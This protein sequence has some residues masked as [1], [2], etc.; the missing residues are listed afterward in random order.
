M[1]YLH[2][3]FTDKIIRAFYNVYNSLGFGFL[4][5]V[6]ENAMMIELKSFGL[7][8]E[9]QTPINVYYK[10][11]RIGEY[12]ADIVVESKV[13]IELK[14]AESLCEEHEAQLLNY[15]KATEIEVGLLLNFGKTP[16]IK[17]KIFENTY[18]KSIKTNGTQI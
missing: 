13:I 5:K 10:E 3:D 16:Q 17:R 14:A 7:H 6:Y 4:E 2:K 11:N 9:K 8:C 1:E 12:F 18:K 15:L